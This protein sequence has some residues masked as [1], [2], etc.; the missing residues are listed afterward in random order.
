[1]KNKL[2][3]RVCLLCSLSVVMKAQS[4]RNLS[5]KELDVFNQHKVEINTYAKISAED[6]LL[7]LRSKYSTT[8]KQTP[9]E[10]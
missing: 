10:K 8:I 7:D 4:S 6:K 5:P 1:M 3:L 9:K 2:L